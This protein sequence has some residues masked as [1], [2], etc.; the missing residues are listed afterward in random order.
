MEIYIIHEIASENLQSMPHG[1]STQQCD[2]GFMTC[3]WSQQQ[4]SAQP[5]EVTLCSTQTSAR[6]LQA[7]LLC[8]SPHPDNVSGMPVR[9][10]TG[11]TPFFCSAGQRVMLT[12]RSRKAKERLSF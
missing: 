12:S 3:G 7:R 1:L 2:S 10:D 11:W 4:Q 6:F 5:A 8:R 9:W